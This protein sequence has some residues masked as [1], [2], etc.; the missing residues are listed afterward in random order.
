MLSSVRREEIFVDGT[1]TPNSSKCQRQKR[2]DPISARD[3][4]SPA[5]CTRGV[6]DRRRASITVRTL[7]SP[8]PLRD[9]LP[10]S[11]CRVEK[12]R[13]SVGSRLDWPT[14]VPIFA[15]S[16]ALARAPLDGHRQPLSRKAYQHKASRV[17]VAP[18]SLEHSVCKNMAFQKYPP[19]LY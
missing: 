16:R 9:R 4:H 18:F 5:L 7:R 17:R 3:T 1:K 11:T 12:P 14:R 13:A 6:S 10:A 15:L 19:I 2:F 8:A